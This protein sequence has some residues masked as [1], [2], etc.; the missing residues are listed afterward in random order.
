MKS[1][2]F[3]ASIL[4]LAM[5]AAQA[6]EG[7]GEPFPNTAA[8]SAV[9]SNQV[10]SDTGSATG[11][12]FGHATSRL[13]QGNVL[14]ENGSA[15]AVQTANSLPRGFENGTVAYTQA[16][17]IQRWA[18]AHQAAPTTRLTLRNTNSYN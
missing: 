2:F 3:A 5:G 15:G 17:S 10:S 6:G 4:V 7:N 14:P 16:Q 1:M 11:P 12:V 13:V 8:G 9:V 18:L